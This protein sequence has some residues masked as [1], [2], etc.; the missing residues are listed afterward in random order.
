MYDPFFKPSIFFKPTD[1]VC[2]D[3]IPFFDGGE[4]K[5]F[6]LKDFRN[7]EDHGEGTPWH[8]V[9]TKDFVKFSEKGEVLARGAANEQDLFVFT[10]SVIKAEGR[11]HIFYTGHN[12]HL[13]RQGKPE[14]GVMHAVSDDLLNWTKLPEHTFYAPEGYEPHDWRDPFVFWNEEKNEYQMLLAARLT[15]GPSRRRGCTALCTSKDLISWEVRQP[16]WAP[17]LYFTHE[18]P[19]LFKVNDWWYLVFSE[20]SDKSVTRYRMSKN[21]EGPWIAPKNDTFDGRAYY[22]A[23]TA[24]DGYKRFIFGWNP[25]RVSESDNGNWMWGGHLVVHEVVQ[26]PEGTLAVRVPESVDKAFEEPAGYPVVEYSFG[27]VTGQSGEKIILDS[28]D[29]YSC[30]MLG[31]MPRLCKISA[32][33]TFQEG[34]KGFGLKLR[35]DKEMEAAYYIRLEPQKSRVVF[36]S[37]PRPG[38]LSHMPGI[39]QSLCLNPNVKHSIKVFVQGSVGVVYV[40]DVAAVNFRMY[41]K[42]WGDW[43]VFAQDAQ[44]KFE[45]VCLSEIKI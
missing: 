10:G 29:G 5:L 43:G 32:D 36:D 8:L 45:N 18:C 37:W 33:F 6:Y 23:K 40:N 25:T 41:D 11:Y 4:F 17:G 44:V 38:D 16:L 9:T 7:Y 24:S 30:A 2:A 1:S 21:L 34:T 13:R 19:D 26:N 12:H 14:Q 42:R 15:T 22:A 31:Q 39:E 28:I 3:F 27:E 20:F 35:S